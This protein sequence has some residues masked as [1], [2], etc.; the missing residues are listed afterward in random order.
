MTRPLLSHIGAIANSRLPLP[1]IN[2]EDTRYYE[3]LALEAG[4][5][6]TKEGLTGLWQRLKAVL[7]KHREKHRRVSHD[8]DLLH[9]FESLEAGTTQTI[10]AFGQQCLQRNQRELQERP[11]S[12]V[13]A[14]AELPTLTEI[15]EL[16]LKKQPHKAPGPDGV[17]SDVGRFG[18]TAVAQHLH[19]LILKSFLSGVEPMRFKGGILCPIW[20]RKGS[21]QDAT[22]YRGIL[23]AD[24]YA[25]V[26]HAWARRRLL[27]TLQCRKTPGQLGGLPS[28]QTAV[29]IHTL[30]LHCR[31]GRLR[32]NLSTGTLFIDLKATFHHMLR[33]MIFAIDNKLTR[34]K[35][36]AF[37]SSTEFNLEQLAHDLDELC[38]QN[39]ADIPEGLRRLLHDIHHHT[40]LQL[41]GGS[42]DVTAT[43]RGT[44]PGSPLADIGFNLLMAK[45]MTQM[46]EGLCSRTCG[47]SSPGSPP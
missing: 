3:S 13:F 15:E 24:M 18:A 43:L 31:L 28:Q 16:C 8:V 41:H 9:H 33:E 45:I 6:Y 36:A 32:H 14:L 29:G 7:P 25:K 20:K 40:W 30:R 21:L 22:S 47:T 27:P 5:T 38:R 37:L 17:P 23:L 44:R 12:Q 19:N 11:V 10:E 46:Q 42:G 35:L 34:D 26:F 39:P 4:H 1:K 2:Q